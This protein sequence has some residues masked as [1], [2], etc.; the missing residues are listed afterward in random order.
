[1]EES[2]AALTDDV[3]IDYQPAVSPDGQWL[4]YA[5]VLAPNQ[6][7]SLRVI[8]VGGGPARELPVPGGMILSPAWSAD[9]SWIYFATTP[10]PNAARTSLW[11]VAARAG[12]DSRP[13]SA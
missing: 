1:M 5:S 13:S 6:R 7:L 4:A 3:E 11:R 2:R 12:A 8:P 9:G 10:T